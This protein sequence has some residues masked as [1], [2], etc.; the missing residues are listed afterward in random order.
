MDEAKVDKTLTPQ[1]NK[2]LNRGAKRFT[3]FHYIL[4]III[5]QTITFTFIY[6]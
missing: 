3:I 4:I 6:F 1:V 2:G 5:I